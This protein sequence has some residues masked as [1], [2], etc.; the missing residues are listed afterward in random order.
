MGNN[1]GFQTSPADGK[2]NKVT[3]VSLSD[4]NLKTNLTPLNNVVSKITGLNV[5]EY[6]FND[7]V[8]PETMIG[9]K[10]YGL[11]AQEV[12]TAFPIVVKHNIEFDGVNYM[13]IDYKELV[14]VLFKAIQELKEEIDLL[15]KNG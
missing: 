5:F 14:P 15:K 12:E 13:G 2:I 3:Q 10:S 4:V 11:I 7:K 1:I 8:K 6:E 9:E